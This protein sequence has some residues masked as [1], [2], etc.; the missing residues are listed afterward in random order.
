MSQLQTINDD[1][2]TTAQIRM[3]FAEYVALKRQANSKKLF[4]ELKKGGAGRY[5]DSISRWFNGGL[6]PKVGAKTETTNFH[7]FRHTFRDALRAI[8]APEEIVKSLGGWKKSGD[9]SEIY[10]WVATVQ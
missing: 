2:D 3:G 8:E 4:P 1:T 10:G 6:L 5:G 9:T 7:C